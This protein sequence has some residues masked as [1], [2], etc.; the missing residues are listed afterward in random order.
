MEIGIGCNLL[1]SIN[2]QAEPQ[3]PV[4]V[5]QNGIA[6]RLLSF[7][8]HFNSIYPKLQAK[9][10]ILFLGFKNFK[11][12]LSSLGNLS[13]EL[14]NL[15]D[16]HSFTSIQ[17]QNQLPFSFSQFSSTLCLFFLLSGA[18]KGL[19]PQRLHPRVSF[20]CEQEDIA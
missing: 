19:G 6:T 17:P 2:G 10:I 5:A 7:V 11:G 18:W 9:A 1:Q 8:L 13:I 3:C 14:N 16:T 15:N 12:C 4:V 20:E